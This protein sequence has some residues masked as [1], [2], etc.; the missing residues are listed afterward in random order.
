MRGKQDHQ[1]ERQLRSG[2][3]EAETRLWHRLRSGR[4][5]GWKFRRQHRIGPYIVDFVCLAH[6]LVV[7]LDG[8]QH[9][10][11][12][13]YDTARTLYLE[14]A[15]YRVL[16]FWNDDALARMDVVLEAIAHTSLTPRPPSAPSPR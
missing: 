1:Y 12:A 15:G 14:S 2:Q 7:E 13:D 10:E 4:L 9:L 3:T 5:S 6:A 8:S 11:A 16:R